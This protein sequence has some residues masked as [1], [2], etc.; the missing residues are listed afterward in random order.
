MY[1][2][3]KPTCKQYPRESVTLLKTI[4]FMWNLDIHYNIQ[5]HPHQNSIELRKTHFTF[6]IAIVSPVGVNAPMFAQCMCQES[7]KEDL[8]WRVL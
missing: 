6:P 2:L 8:D 7:K 3:D 1:A 4:G 5:S